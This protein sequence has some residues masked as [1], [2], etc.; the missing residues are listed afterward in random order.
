MNLYQ[1]LST[2]EYDANIVIYT[3]NDFDQCQKV[4]QGTVDDARKDDDVWFYLMQ[5]VEQWIAGNKCVLLFI[6]PE[7][8]NKLL[9][10][11]IYISSYKVHEMFEMLN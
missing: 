11:E 6:K 1:M 3:R 2:A 8:S 9:D 7:D 10:G 5:R 4:F